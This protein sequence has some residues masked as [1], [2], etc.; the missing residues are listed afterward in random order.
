MTGVELRD[1]ADLIFRGGVLDFK[2]QLILYNE[3]GSVEELGI[4]MTAFSGDRILGPMEPSAATV[5]T[6]MGDPVLTHKGAWYGY[7]CGMFLCLITAISMLF[8]DE[9]FRWNLS[10]RIRNA[11]RVEPTD[12]EIASRQI[13]WFLLP[14]LTLFLFIIGLH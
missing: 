8:A 7:F 13:A 3:D 2:D 5:L 1:G 9:L 11:D 6:L 14:I 4:S 12:W 10:F